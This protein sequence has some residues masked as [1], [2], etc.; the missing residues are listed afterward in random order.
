MNRNFK[1]KKRYTYKMFI[2][3]IPKRPLKGITFTTAVEIIQFP[4]YIFANYKKE[5]K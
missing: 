2:N 3:F 4:N 5:L 1:V